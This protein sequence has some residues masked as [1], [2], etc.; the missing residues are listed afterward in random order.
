MAPATS[1]GRETADCAVCKSTLRMRALVA[2][3]SREIFGVAMA[4]PEFPTM[5]GIRGIGMSDSPELAQRLAEKFDYTNTFYHQAPVFD[6]TNPD[7]RD[8]GRYDFIVSSEVMEH[9]SP[10]VERAFQ[11]LH[12]MLKADGLL[13]MTT[14]YSLGGKTAEHF[15]DLHEFTL[16]S[17]GGRPVL[18][19]RRRDGATEVIEDLVFHGG[20]G[21]I[22]EM[23]FFTD[24]SLRDALL[25]AGFTS[26]HFSAENHP[27][28]A[29][30]HTE[31]FS[32]PM[33]ARKGQFRAPGA[34]L[35]KEYLEA[36]RLAA[37]N[38]RELE[39]LTSDYQRYIAFHEDS[40]DRLERDLAERVDWA[41]KIDAESE[42]L[43]AWAKEVD[44]QK[45]Q[46]VA[47]F[48]HLEDVEKE[49]RQYVAIL[50]KEST[51][52]QTELRERRAKI[53]KLQSAWWTR[54]G[55]RLGALDR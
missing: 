54:I 45:N 21:S 22:L 1:G 37:R 11:S 23:R 8:Q 3:L 48:L 14:P 30:G 19:N 20:H 13:L 2:L 50:E 31:P 36:F 44:R 26:V 38:I 51:E 43:A 33:V 41:R 24:Q 18:V 47:D 46:T 6:V 53:E 7:G 25:G 55:R 5:K 4:L 29:V 10:P 17:L 32:L 27:E 39:I 35:A 34:E 40:Q 52:Q 49:L 9:V 28:F 12:A 16:A 42:Q 15:P